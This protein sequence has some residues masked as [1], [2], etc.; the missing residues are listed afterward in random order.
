MLSL[1]SLQHIYFHNE[2]PFQVGNSWGS[3]G[4]TNTSE[5]FDRYYFTGISRSDT[6][7]DFKADAGAPNPVLVNYDLEDGSNELFSWQSENPADATAA[8]QPAAHFMITNRFNINSTSVAA[9]K[10]ALGSLR[11]RDYYYLD[12]PEEDTSRFI[13]TRRWQR[14]ERPHVC[15]IFTFSSRNL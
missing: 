1:A 14:I 15:Q 13:Y 12:Y 3:E 7:D 8:R 6:A 2:R 11:I 5:W 10:A 4:T 9:W